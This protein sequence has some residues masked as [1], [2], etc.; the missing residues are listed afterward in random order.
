MDGDGDQWVVM[1]SVGG[2][3]DQWVAMGISGW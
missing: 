2:D 1:G 3:G